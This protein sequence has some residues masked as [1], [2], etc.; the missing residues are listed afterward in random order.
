M[1]LINYSKKI[2]LALREQQDIRGIA[3]K[4]QIN[5]GQQIIGLQS[6]AARSHQQT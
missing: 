3:A 2:Y 5:T 1:F 6:L 4:F